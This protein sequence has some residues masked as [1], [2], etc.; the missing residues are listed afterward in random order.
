MYAFNYYAHGCSDHEAVMDQ[1]RAG[2]KLITK[3]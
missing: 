2:V 3:S 1:V